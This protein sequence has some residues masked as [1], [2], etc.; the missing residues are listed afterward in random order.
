[1]FLKNK[2]LSLYLN[3]IYQIIDALH[4]LHSKQIH[5]LDERACLYSLVCIS[6]KPSKRRATHSL[7]S[8]IHNYLAK[9]NVCMDI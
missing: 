4:Y 9:P 8:A 6:P 2:Y 5:I 7:M 1:M 3:I